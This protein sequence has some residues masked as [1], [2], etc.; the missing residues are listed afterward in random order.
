[1]TDTFVIRKKNR[2]DLL[3]KSVDTGA[4]EVVIQDILTEHVDVLKKFRKDVR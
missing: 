4:F 3:R 2:E 1:M